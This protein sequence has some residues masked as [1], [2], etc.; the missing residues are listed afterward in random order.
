MSASNET[1]HPAAMRFALL[2]ICGCLLLTLDLRAAAEPNGAPSGAVREVTRAFLF[3]RIY[4]G[5][6][7][8][9]IGG[10]EGLPHEF[11]YN[12]RPRD[13][14]PEFTF[15]EKGACSDDDNDFEWTHLWFMD[16]EGVLKLPY[17]W[18]VGIWKANM[19]QGIWVANKRARE[20]MDQGLVPPETGRTNVNPHAGYNLSGQFCVEAYGM[21]AP[22]LPQAAADLGL[23]YARIAVSEEPLQATQFW[24][25]LISLMA[26]HE[27]RLE[28]AFEAAL[29]AVDPGSAMAEVVAD[30][31]RLHRE[32]PRDW[33]AARQA[34]HE[35]PCQRRA[36]AARLALRRRRFLQNAAIR[37]GAGLRRG[38]QRRDG[39]RGRG[40]AAWLP[41]HRRAAAVQDARPLREQDPPVAAGRM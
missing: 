40:D 26:F 19:N 9:L 23:H 17:P 4:G 27:G 5:W 18:L 2:T 15:L 24:T 37:H 1:S 30:A 35:N 32:H 16:K 14:L 7:G 3:D 34:V 28:T 11:K 39:R 13:T 36:R 6:A 12:E 31:R 25:S 22:G 20:L 33:K 38:L 10:L 8:M 41:S 29:A 21:I